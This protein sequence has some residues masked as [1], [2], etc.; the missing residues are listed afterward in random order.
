MI[1]LFIASGFIPFF[2]DTSHMCLLSLNVYDQNIFHDLN[3]PHK[4]YPPLP[5][6]PVG[7]EG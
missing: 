6:E 2:S 5:V 3:V 1:I 7:V 4:S